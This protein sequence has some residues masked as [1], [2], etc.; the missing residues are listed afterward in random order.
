MVIDRRLAVL[1][2][3]ALLTAALVGVALSRDV[4]NRNVEPGPAGVAGGAEEEP[5]APV[6]AAP[7]GEPLEPEAASLITNRRPSRVTAEMRSTSCRRENT[8]PETTVSTVTLS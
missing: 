7:D 1:G 5:V 2:A 6:A 4:D 8:R 3:T